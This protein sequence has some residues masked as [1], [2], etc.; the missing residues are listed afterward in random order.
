M[1]SFRP[2]KPALGTKA[3]VDAA[4][5]QGDLPIRTMSSPTLMQPPGPSPASLDRYGNHARS[6]SRL[7]ALGK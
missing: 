3:T 5:I 6:Y 1:K 2:E 4:D 7:F